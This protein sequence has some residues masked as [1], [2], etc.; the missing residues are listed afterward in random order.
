[1]VHVIGLASGAFMSSLGVNGCTKSWEAH[2]YN[3][4]FGENEI[5]DTGKSQRLR[6]EGN[7]GINKVLA[8][9]PSLGKIIDTVRISSYFESAETDLYIAENASCIDYTDTWS[10]KPV[11]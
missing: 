11:H 2:E 7:G 6:R 9:R 4:Q 1:M 5:T 10:P 8:M 3:Q